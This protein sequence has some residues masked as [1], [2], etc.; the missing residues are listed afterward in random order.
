[1]TTEQKLSILIPAYNEKETINEILEKIEQTQ[2]PIE[3]EVVIVDDG[4]TDGTREILD[5]MRD[6]Y[7]IVFHEENAGKG[8]AIRTG[9]NHI[10]GSHVVIQDADLEYDPQD[11]V[12]MIEKMLDE[13]LPVLYGSRLLESKKNEKAG[14]TYYLGGQV[15]TVMTNVLYGQHITDEPTCYKMFKAELLKEL[16]LMCERFEFCPEVTALVAKKGIKIPEIPIAYYPRGKE[17]GK[18]IRWRD[19]WEAIVVLLKYRI[20]K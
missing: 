19:G 9:I 13:N 8:S 10:T 17:E 4:S 14:M 1:M 5:G 3:K 11:L 2:F 7:T 6:R 18:K 12:K 20:K 16:P 15:L